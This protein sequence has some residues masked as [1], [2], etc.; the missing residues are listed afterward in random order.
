MTDSESRKRLSILLASR[1]QFLAF[2]ER[3]VASRDEAEEILQDAFARGVERVVDV[4]E[5]GNVVAWFYRILRNAIVDRHRR[6]PEELPGLEIDS[7]ILQV[8]A[9]A[10]LQRDVCVCIQGLLPLIRPDYA[11]LVRL[12]DLEGRS[13]GAVA[14][15][16]GVSAGSARVRLHRARAALRREVQLT[17]RACAEHGCL[18]CSCARPPRA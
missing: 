17:C 8:A 13:V 18:D 14:K 15:D 9:D 3:R 7:D 16:R 5:E 1:R 2:V 12:V 6:R 10:E 11:E 4:R